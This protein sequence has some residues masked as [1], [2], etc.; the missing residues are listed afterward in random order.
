MVTASGFLF[1]VG[2]ANVVIGWGLWKQHEW[3]RIGA[4]VLA[5][6]RLLSFPIGTAIGALTLWYL[7]R[8]D[9]RKEFQPQPAALEPASAELSPAPAAPP[10][11]VEPV[12]EPLAA[13][14]QP[15]G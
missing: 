7:L 14:Q 3:G 10:E 4:L 11:A 8:E 1:L 13:L 5:V 12:P 15:K 6:L 2:V 9:V